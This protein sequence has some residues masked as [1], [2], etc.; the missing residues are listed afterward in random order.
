MMGYRHDGSGMGGGPLDP[1]VI[2]WLW[3]FCVG[4]SAAAVLIGS[5]WLDTRF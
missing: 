2:G 5:I 3:G 4:F 1:K